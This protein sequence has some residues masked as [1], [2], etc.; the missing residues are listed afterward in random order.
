LIQRRDVTLV[1]PERSEKTAEQVVE[2]NI[3]ISGDKDFC[4]RNAI[5]KPPGFRKLGLS[6]PLGEITTGDH[7][8]GPALLDTRE[9]ILHHINIVPPKM[10]V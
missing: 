7:Q 2:W 6:G 9:E 8:V 5:Q 3:V 1:L 4:G 10:Q